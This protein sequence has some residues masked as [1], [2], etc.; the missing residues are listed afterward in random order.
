MT[1]TTEE[2]RTP[3]TYSRRSVLKGTAIGAGGAVLI[4]TVGTGYRSEANG[5]WNSGEGEP[6]ELWS[7]WQDLPGH[8]AI[9]GAGI[10]AANPHN[11]Q[12]WIFA[13]EGDTITVSSDTSRTMPH[14]DTDA[15][16]HLAGLGCAVE[17]MV[18]AARG[19]GLHA[20]VRTWPSPDVAA[21]L[22]LVPGPTPTDRELAL[23]AAI[24]KRHTHRGPFTSDAVSSDGLA[25]LGNSDAGVAAALG[26]SVHWVTDPAAVAALG[27]L[28][29]DATQAIIDDED[30]SVEGFAWFRSTRSSIEKHRDGLTLGCQGLSSFMLAAAKILPASPRTDGDAFWLKSTRDTHT[31]TAAAYGVIAV[32]DTDDA[33]ARIDGGR[34]LERLHVA[35]TAD[36]LAVHHMNQVSERIVRDAALGA[37]S[38][39]AKHWESI[40]G[41]PASRSLVAFRIGHPDGTA[42]RSP[43]RA[44]EAVLTAA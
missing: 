35:A 27:E 17:N 25:R 36:G 37:S 44:V 2:P 19:L 8:K 32:S 21:R 24:S 1:Y 43:R 13:I 41:L 30:M 14:T 40:V 7:T 22:T 39:F 34:L 11:T 18:M 3:R 6:Y 26:A 28:Y 29:V 42:R 20:T 38:S 31:A 33:A 15:R 10:L 4:G 16:E 23:V 12:P 9:V 5:V